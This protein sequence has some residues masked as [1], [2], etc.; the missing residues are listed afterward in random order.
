MLE[1]N[2]FLAHKIGDQCG[3]CIR[4]N[5]NIEAAKV[6]YMLNSGKKNP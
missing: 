2:S 5:P 4:D 3:I 6:T 1:N